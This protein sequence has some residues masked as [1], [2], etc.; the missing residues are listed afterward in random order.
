MGVDTDGGSRKRTLGVKTKKKMVWLWWLLFCLSA[1][2]CVNYSLFALLVLMLFC[3][4]ALLV[5]LHII[6][7]ICMFVCVAGCKRKK[8]F[9]QP[10]ELVNKEGKTKAMRV[11][12]GLIVWCKP[13]IH[14][15]PWVQHSGKKIT[16]SHVYGLKG[17]PVGVSQ[18]GTCVCVRECVR[19]NRFDF[20][21]E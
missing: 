7:L 3:L 10:T 1:L 6:F 12:I 9:E 18:N 2:L 4:S 21:T 14:Q 13:H 17:F 8:K 11:T 15:K 19:L 16:W 20:C 5:C